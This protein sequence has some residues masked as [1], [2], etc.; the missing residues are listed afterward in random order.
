[1]PVFHTLSTHR[2]PSARFRASF[3][4]RR[5]SRQQPPPPPPSTPFS[6]AF[7][8]VPPRFHHGF[9]PLFNRFSP[10]F[11][12]AKSTTIV[13]RLL[14]QSAANFFSLRALRAIHRAKRSHQK[15]PNESKNSSGASES[16]FL[17]PFR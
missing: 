11:S 6:T 7:I 5:S 15:R 1:M 14:Y 2:A 17:A 10:G 16:P 12:P 4:D 13:P 3:L 9:I 8:P